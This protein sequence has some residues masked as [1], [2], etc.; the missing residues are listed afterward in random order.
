[1]SYLHSLRELMRGGAQAAQWRGSQGWGL[2]GKLGP[3]PL[4]EQ[5]AEE[6]FPF[7]PRGREG[8]A[9]QGVQHSLIPGH[10]VDRAAR[11]SWG[12]YNCRPHCPQ[13]HAGQQGRCFAPCGTILSSLTD[14]NNT[15]ILGRTHCYS[16]NT[17]SPRK[18]GGLIQTNPLPCLER[19][20]P[21]SV[22]HLST[23]PS[24]FTGI[25]VNIKILIKTMSKV[26]VLA[27]G[28]SSDLA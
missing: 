1:M 24:P 16:R 17:R 14:D 9:A 11:G 6:V 28:H 8:A 27:S 22:A 20:P 18:E 13:L 5:G 7:R 3:S 26:L 12:L 4:R 2:P 25:Y 21:Q 19:Q 10:Q 15:D 23:I